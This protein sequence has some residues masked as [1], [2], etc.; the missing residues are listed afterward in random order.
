MFPTCE[1]REISEALPHRRPVGR[2]T[3]MILALLAIGPSLATAEESIPNNSESESEPGAL[4]DDVSDSPI[5]SEPASQGSGEGPGE[6]ESL[7]AA[8]PPAVLP[9]ADFASSVDVSAIEEPAAT[10][11]LDEPD[12]RLAY[13]PPEKHRWRNLVEL[14]AYIGIG[15]AWYWINEERQVA[16]WDYPR[17]KDKVTFNPDIMIFDNNDFEVNY[18]WHTFAGGASHLLGRSNGLGIA[19][20][21]AFGTLASVFWEYVIESREL[22]SVNDLLITNTTGL[23]TGEFFHRVGQ[24]VNQGQEGLAWDVARWTVGIGHTGHAWYDD[25]PVPLDLALTPDFRFYYSLESADIARQDGD[26]AR[27][28][29]SSMQHTVGFAGRMVALD[30]YMQ[31]GKHQEW[32]GAANFSDFGISHSRGE[33]YATRSNASTLLAGWRHQDLPKRGEG[34]IGTTLNVATSVGYLYHRE[35]YGVWKDRLAGLHAPGLALEG[36]L[37]GDHWKLRAEVNASFDLMGINSLSWQQYRVV[38][39]DIGK[40]ILQE[41]SYYY[42]YGASTR[43][44]LS[45]DVS[46]FTLAASLFAA[47][48]D[49]IEGYD[50][51]KATIEN[52]ASGGDDFFDYELSFRGN[53]YK[54]TYLQARWGQNYR[55]GHLDEFFASQKLNRANLE[56]GLNF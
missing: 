50:R 24:Y 21:F 35:E 8:A 53:L 49:S 54:K 25:K 46:R 38:R 19:E 41:S 12:P 34:G 20:S 13:L 52:E 40:S 51:L 31:P 22:I 18:T 16:D 9:T 42:G 4:D 6:A 1:E 44:R 27:Q 10:L 26:A 45:L 36:E 28:T 37:V 2:V 48:Y 15:T 14:F 3:W 17:W 7:E 56:L 39:E 5:D 11:T 32:F 43:A 23:P 29:G 47:R 55:Q 33:G 30:S